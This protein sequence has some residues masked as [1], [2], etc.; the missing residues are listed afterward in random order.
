M[1]EYY[2]DPEYWLHEIAD[3]EAETDES[4]GDYAY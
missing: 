2:L 1:S 3:D 4:E